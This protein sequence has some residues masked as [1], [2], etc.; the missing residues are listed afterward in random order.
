MS[1]DTHE[2][3]GFPDPAKEL[4]ELTK[5]ILETKKALLE[6]KETIKV[7][8]TLDRY[9]RRSR[10]MIAALAISFLLD[11]ILTL[12]V[13]IVGLTAH[14]TAATLRTDEINECYSGNITRAQEAD[15]W[16]TFIGILV[17]PVKPAGVSEAQ[18]TADKAIADK[19][20]KTV[21]K[22]FAPRNC[23]AIYSLSAK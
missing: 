1:E 16:T 13:A 11:I 12:V 6:T 17:P 22:D 15:I 9:A 7:V 23:I 3:P 20:L 10:H 2:T 19:F 14:S 4:A 8:P 5:S 21:N 18:Y